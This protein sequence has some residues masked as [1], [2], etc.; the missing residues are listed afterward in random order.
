MRRF[1]G[2]IGVVAATSVVLFTAQPAYATYPGK[3]G[4]I[5]FR[6]YLNARHSWGAIFTINPNALVTAG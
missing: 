6:R 5:S 4:R 1:V 3:N 2:A